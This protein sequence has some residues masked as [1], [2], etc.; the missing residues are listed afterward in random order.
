MELADYRDRWNRLQEIK[1][2]KKEIHERV[3]NTPADDL[4]LDAIEKELKA[5]ND[6]QE[7]LMKPVW[8]LAERM[9]NSE[10]ES[11][12]EKMAIAEKIGK[13]EIE[14]RHIPN[15][16]NQKEGGFPKLIETMNPEEV[17]STQEY[18]SAFFKVMVG[19]E[20]DLTDAEKRA[21]EVEKRMFTTG[22]AGAAIPTHVHEE[23]MKKLKQSSALF[24]HIRV[25]QLPG[26]VSIPVETGESGASWVEEGADIPESG[27]PLNSVKL[28]GYTLAK[29]VP[30][31][32]AVESMSASAFENYLADIIPEK[33]LIEIEKAIV[34]GS[35]SGQPTGI[36]T[37]VTWTT[38]V[39]SFSYTAGSLGYDDLMKPLA[40][41]G[42]AYLPNAKW[43]MHS[44]TLYGEV[45]KIKDANNKPIFVQ[46]TAAGVEGR[47]MGK[48]VVVNDYM[49]AGTI[50]FG[51]FRYY[52]MNF[53]QPIVFEKSRESGFRRAT[54]DYRAVA[55]ADGKPALSEAFIKL[56]SA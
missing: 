49:P 27:D 5:L 2:R 40:N 25:T 52:M 22:S 48:P 43:C 50:L 9:A 1:A 42:A 53:P 29:L 20:A 13:G 38:D 45:A 24:P 37:G 4:D 3:K 34:S 21:L 55:V 30:V 23:V 6:E 46:D 44:A 14:A 35:G 41:M 32:I 15:P 19:K 12:A 10:A 17:R 36:L 7:E 8:D 31:P 54:I 28:A 39:N 56:E 33:L 47:L 18:R 51:D 11:R 16:L 26:N